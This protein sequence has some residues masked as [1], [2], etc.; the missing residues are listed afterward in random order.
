MRREGCA[1]T[2]SRSTPLTTSFF[3]CHALPPPAR[4]RHLEKKNATDHNRNIIIKM[5]AT[6]AAVGIS[7]SSSS[8]SS[9]AS[10]RRGSPRVSS[11]APRPN[12]RRAT[13]APATVVVRAGAIDELLGAK[14]IAPN[15]GGDG[16]VRDSVSKYYGETLKTSDDLKTSACCTP[17]LL[18]KAVR[19][20]LSKVPDEVKAKYY[21][22]GSPTPLGI[23][24][25][26]VLDLGSGSGRD[27]YVASALVGAEGFVTGV[28]MTDGQLEV[29][30]AKRSAHRPRN[31]HDFAKKKKKTKK[32][33]KDERNHQQIKDRHTL[34]Y[35]SYG[36]KE[37]EPRATG[38]LLSFSAIFLKK[39]L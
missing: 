23:E 27:C 36:K 16:E 33:G 31:P 5:A 20:I 18:P 39:L 34:S 26:R 7:S 29:R 1:H 4:R 25:L 15:G 8:S 17:N 38:A 30:E 3:F 13:T 32:M 12:V 14:I 10:R 11:F 22:C 35:V 21:G 2:S 9:L 24:G 6:A 37:K 28:D 19:D